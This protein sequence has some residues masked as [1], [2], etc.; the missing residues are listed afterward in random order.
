MSP[1]QPSTFSPVLSVSVRTATPISL[2]GSSPNAL[3]KS[4]T[5]LRDS[6]CHWPTP[7]DP[8]DAT[9]IWILDVRG[10][11]I[12]LP[13][14][15]LFDQMYISVAYAISRPDKSLPVAIVLLS[16]NDSFDLSP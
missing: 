1:Y 5:T 15:S 16:D 2:P 11:W 7:D 6:F 13:T 4:S 10:P 8:L 9:T 14:G 12:T 3:R